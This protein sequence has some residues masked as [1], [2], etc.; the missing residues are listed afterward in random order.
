M[1]MEPIF[2]NKFKHTKE[3]YIEMNKK[4]TSFS[5]FFLSLFFL[6]V[7]W[8][9]AVFIY[10]YLYDL[11]FAIIIAFAGVIFSI[12]PFARIPFIARKREKQL[13]ELYDTI[14]E[15]D[16]MFYDDCLMSVSITSKEELKLNYSKI[17]KVK[18]S[19]NLYLLILNN[20][21]AVMVDKNHFEKG[22]CEEF[23]K[24]IKEKAVNAKIRL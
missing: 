11:I 5:I 17:K 7:Y 19:K 21:L 16:T 4:C 6:I 9:L 14:P 20:K 24:F 13:L 18:Q 10:H 22:T 12:Y 15:C 23:E 3:S 2:I 1:E 8:T